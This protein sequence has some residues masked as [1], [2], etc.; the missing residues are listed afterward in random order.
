MDQI[1]ITESLVS[2]QRYCAFTLDVGQTG[3][4]IDEGCLTLTRNSAMLLRKL[5]A[6]SEHGFQTMEDDEWNASKAFWTVSR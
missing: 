5:L 2:R 6:K 3:I 4:W 1:I